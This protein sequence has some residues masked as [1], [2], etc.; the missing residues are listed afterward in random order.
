M[1]SQ[2][3][4]GRGGNPSLCRRK[5][6]HQLWIRMLQALQ[7]FVSHWD[8]SAKAPCCLLL[9]YFLYFPSGGLL[10]TPER[11]QFLFW[12]FACCSVLL[13]SDWFHWGTL[14]IFTLSISEVA[15][16][17][18]CSHLP[19]PHWLTCCLIPLHFV[20]FL[21][22]RQMSLLDALHSI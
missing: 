5:G 2:P 20:S 22:S 11:L 14:G 4:A 10:S 6:D 12:I 8:K 19:N 7:R 17:Y 16:R 1:S 3:D 15:R 13:R 21:K 18:F 9:L